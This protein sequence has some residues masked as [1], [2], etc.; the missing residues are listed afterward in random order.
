LQPSLQLN[1]KAPSKLM[2]SASFSGSRSWAR[3]ND[4][5]IN[6]QMPTITLF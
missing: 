4:P 6:S 5:L 3:T 2:L 1:K